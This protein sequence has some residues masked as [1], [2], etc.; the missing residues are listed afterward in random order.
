MID[1]LDHLVLT[2][3]NEEACVRF[4]VDALGMTLETFGAGR[5]AFRFGN[6]KINLHVKGHEFEPKADVPTPG[7]LDL[8]F[9]ASVP[10]EAVIERL[11]E[12]GVAIIEGPVM[13]TG[14]TSRIRSVYVR[15]PDLNLIE[16]S[17]LAP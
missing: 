14:A 12:K 1:H 9:I 16:I 13:R 2:T 7:S 11:G 8:C 5:K 3:A 17:E 10:L 4:Y 15:D 6:Q